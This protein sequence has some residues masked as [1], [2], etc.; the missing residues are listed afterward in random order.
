ME[1]PTLRQLEYFVAV[2]EQ[3]N[4]SKAAEACHVSQPALSA[5][6][7]QLESLLGL[8]LFE[9]DRRGVQLTAAGEALVGPAQEVLDATDRVT[10]LAKSQ[11]V[12]L[13]GPLRI[14]TIP[15]VGPYLLPRVLPQ[16][17]EA[18]PDLQIYLREDTT[19]RLLQQLDEGQLDLLLL[20][21]DIDLGNVATMP[22]FSDPF[23]LAVSDRDELTHAESA[24]LDDLEGRDLLLLD[25]GH[26][27]REQTL[28][29]CE[30][31]GG[32][33][34]RGFRASSLGT[35]AQ[36]VAGGLGSTLLPELAV[37]REAAAAPR[38]VTLPFGA[39]GPSRSVGLAWRKRCPRGDEFRRLGEV[40]ARAYA[41][42]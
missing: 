13:T 5:Q 27:L 30:A 19:S 41:R 9:R 40:I 24:T 12:P 11:G 26:C 17:H 10:Q 21:I 37:E 3:L 31:S 18:F 7:A 8:P 33:E 2:A 36:M 15:T 16:V 25:E 34:L 6:I 42:S 4:F 22:L 39:D 28:P 38:L 23:T 20:A 35:I 1:R 29:L 32:D 14:G